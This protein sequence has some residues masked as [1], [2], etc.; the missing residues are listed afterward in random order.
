[1]V[2]LC[3]NRRMTDDL[4]PG[5]Q[6]R[7]RRLLATFA[8]AAALGAP[9]LV[10][11]QA[12]A[13]PPGLPAGARASAVWDT[14]PGKLPLVKR[15]WR[16]PNYETPVRVF[17]EAFTPNEAFFVRYHLAGIPRIDPAQW[18]LAVG[19]DAA[20]SPFELDLA[21]LRSG[22]ET[23][24]VAALC[25]CSGNRRG[26]A[27]P[28]VPGVQWGHGAMGNARWRGVRLR[29]VL[30]RAGLRADALEVAFDGADQGAGT[31]PDFVKSL[32]AW[33][34]L[35]ENT[36]LAFEMNGEPLP[37]WHGSPVR[38]VV[39]GWTATYWIK[40]LVRIEARTAPLQGFWMS[41]AY[42]LPR[43]R[44]PGL[45]PFVSQDTETTTPITAMVVN[46]LITNIRDQS[47]FRAATPLFVRGVAWDGGPGVAG[48]EV[49]IDGGR[50]FAAARLG[51]DLGRFAWRQWSFAFTP[52]AGEYSLVARATSRS[53]ATQPSEWI[54]NPAGYHHN[55]LQPVAIR[56]A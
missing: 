33:K 9:V 13:G 20:A 45:D 53:G 8:G 52:A 54:P 40:H 26:L 51:P 11:A 44:F 41:P 43:G 1:M 46:S 5:A 6:P 42:R 17:A 55:A 16:P 7:R 15:T 32:P 29:D 10:R 47:L 30:A 3:Q 49:S 56:C 35:D 38:L 34:A 14:L 28:H 18:R 24:E 39:P 48:V 36:L 27:E 4:Q 37:H 19:G 21:G 25:L 12:A 22:F 2:G 31:T 23:V 50:S